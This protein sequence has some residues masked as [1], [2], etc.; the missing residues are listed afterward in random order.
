MQNVCFQVWN[1][2]TKSFVFFYLSIMPLTHVVIV[3][4]LH[5]QSVMMS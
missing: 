3:V 4:V 5:G 1:Q 2:D